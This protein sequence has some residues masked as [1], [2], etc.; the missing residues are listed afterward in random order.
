M[1][2]VI[3]AILAITCPLWI[4]PALLIFAVMLVVVGAYEAILEL[5]EGKK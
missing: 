1:N 5:L 3:A 4:V 2:K